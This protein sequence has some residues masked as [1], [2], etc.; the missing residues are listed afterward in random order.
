MLTCRLSA[1]FLYNQPHMLHAPAV[2]DA[3]ADDIDPR[4]VD[5]AVTENVSEFRD[6]FLDPVEDTS[7]QVAQ[8]MRKHLVRIDVRFFAQCLHIPPDV[9]PTDRLC[10][11]RDE[12]TS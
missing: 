11:A 6:V 5:T 3:G 2:L 4:R 9:R 8:I 12:E 1:G 10:G 7:K